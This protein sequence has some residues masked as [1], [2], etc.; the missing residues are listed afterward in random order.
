MIIPA[1]LHIITLPFSVRKVVS[2]RTMLT[3]CVEVS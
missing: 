2:K 3:L 1:D